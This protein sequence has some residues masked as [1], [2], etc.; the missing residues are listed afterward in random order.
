MHTGN[1]EAA[2]LEDVSPMEMAVLDCLFSGG[3]VLS[4][5]ALFLDELPEIS[6]LAPTLTYL[7]LSF[8]NLSV[9]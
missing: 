6:M 5:K 9:C 2:N 8:N 4:F 7:N 3:Q 1:A